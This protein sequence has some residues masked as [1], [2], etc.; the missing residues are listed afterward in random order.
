MSSSIKIK[1]D[2]YNLSYSKHS[3]IVSTGQTSIRNPSFDSMVNKS[4]SNNQSIA[5]HS[6][7]TGYNNMT[8]SKP[9]TVTNL[10]YSLEPKLDIDKNTVKTNANTVIDGNATSPNATSVS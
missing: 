9:V 1:S 3:N 10:I 4:Q 8:Y 2:E 7:T 5:K 6:T